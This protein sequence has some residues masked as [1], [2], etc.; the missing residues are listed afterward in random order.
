MKY[1]FIRNFLGWSESAKNLS[2]NPTIRKFVS[3]AAMMLAFFLFFVFSISV[4][5]AATFTVTTT[6]DNQSNG[7]NLGL[8]TLR[9]AVNDANASPGDDTINFQAGIAGTI[10][11]IDG[12]L[13]ITSNITINGPNARNLSVSGNNSSRIFVVSGSNVTANI[14]RL[15]ITNGNA[16]PIL[17]GSTLIGDGGAI[18]NAAG[19]TLNLTEVTVS[20]NSATSLGGAIATRAVSPLLTT[21]TT[22][23]TRSAI[24]NNT[25]IAGGGGLSNVG[26]DVFGTGL[27]TA[28]YTTI[29]N[30]TI[31]QNNAS[32]EG[33]GLS[34]DGGIVSLNN[35][36]I[37]HNQSAVAGGGI[38]NVAGVVLGFINMRNNILA[39]NNALLNSNLISSDGLGIV[40]SLG[41]NLIGNNVDIE[42]SF[43]ASVFVGGICQPNVNA[44]LVGSVSVNTQIINPLLG[45][46]ANN[47]GQTDTRELLAGSPAINQADNCVEANNCSTNPD[48]NNPPAALLNDQRGTGFLRRVNFVVDIGAY[49]VQ[50]S[51]TA[52]NVSISGRVTDA[53]GR[54]ISRVRV[55]ITD[56][57]GNIRSS[58]TNQFGYYRFADLPSGETYV[59]QAAHKVYT[60]AP[61]I[62][63]VTEDIS[64]VD[65]TAQQQSLK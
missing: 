61:Q 29:T 9:E 39:Q 56:T 31:T 5:N 24:F 48:G 3:K 32:A 26:V 23:I 65:L 27:L 42:A 2:L 54:A 17:I 8:C 36:T 19:A 53:N 47:G 43:A 49:E 18:L 57:N 6:A 63:S 41:H 28:A 52:A 4:A 35:N 64:D 22:N 46:L 20:G 14:S 10:L 58:A 33:G 15:T 62:I 60:F 1:N 16:Q 34:N 38:V 37:S 30:S 7:C 11:L 51:P 55:T 44:D 25:A 13:P 45:A 40:N 50:L 59:I 21:T 12:H